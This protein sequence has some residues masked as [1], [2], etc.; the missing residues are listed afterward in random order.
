MPM[1]LEYFQKLSK[2]SHAW[3]WNKNNKKHKEKHPYILMIAIIQWVYYLDV[4]LLQSIS[5]PEG[6]NA[7]INR[8]LAGPFLS[9]PHLDDVSVRL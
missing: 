6:A 9:H 8:G 4:E 7:L 3:N 2:L 5:R 1:K